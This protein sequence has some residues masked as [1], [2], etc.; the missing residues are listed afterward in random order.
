PAL[1]REGEKT[2]PG[3]LFGFLREPIAIRPVTTLRMPKFNM[4][5]EDAMQL[6]NYFSAADKIGNP[7]AGLSY[8]YF[9]IPEKDESYIRQQ[10]AR[11]VQRLKQAKAPNKQTTVFEQ[12][13]EEMQPVW[14]EELKRQLFDTQAALQEI[15]TQLKR[16]EE[17]DP[18]KPA[19]EIK[20]LQ[21]T[22]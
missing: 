5:D 15:E 3:W 8:P 19:E 10:T 2:Q 7:A 16:A 22:R 20:K 11:Y 9:S 17:A 21:D 4:S 14:Q 13:L 6:V 18:K 12:R 1:I